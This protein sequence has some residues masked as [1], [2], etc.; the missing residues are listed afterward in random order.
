MT[1]FHLKNL[2]LCWKVKDLI[3]YSIL[4]NTKSKI[5]VGVAQSKKK[6]SEYILICSC[7]SVF[8]IGARTQ[9]QNQIISFIIYIYIFLL[10]IDKKVKNCSS[11]QKVKVQWCFFQING[12][13]DEVPIQ[14][15]KAKQFFFY[16][17]S[18]FAIAIVTQ[19][20]AM[21][22]HVVGILVMLF[23]DL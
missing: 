17:F 15:I 9:V 7:F 16:W 23:P 8:L 12:F 20:V 5:N 1:Y 18:Q 3:V 22:K 21:A 6:F 11:G 19:K 13:V 4:Y 14:C 2:R 10:L